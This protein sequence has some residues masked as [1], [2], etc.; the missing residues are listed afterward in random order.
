MID[1]EANSR[2]KSEQSRYLGFLD[3]R[4]PTADRDLESLG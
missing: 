4:G 3:W 1:M 2:K